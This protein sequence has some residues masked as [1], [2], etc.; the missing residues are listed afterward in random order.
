MKGGAS[1]WTLPAGYIGSGL[2]GSCLV[3]AGFNTVA[4][5]VASICIGVCMLVT[6]WWAR[7]SWF[8]LLSVIFAIGG[9]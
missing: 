1:C 6:L 7:R 5:K 2:I 3:F 9:E 4:S 8:T